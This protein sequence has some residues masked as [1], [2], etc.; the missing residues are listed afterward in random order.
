LT[1]T[2]LRARFEERAALAE[3]EGASAPVANVYKVV[4]DDLRAL[5]GTE[6]VPVPVAAPDPPAVERHLTPE[7]VED[8][9][10]LPRGY[11]Y[12]HKRQLGGVKVGKYLRFPESAIR[13]RLERSR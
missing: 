5:D 10:H 4:L 8:L 9:L 7:Q 11:A 1:L 3:R 6:P 2:E 13:R 12:D